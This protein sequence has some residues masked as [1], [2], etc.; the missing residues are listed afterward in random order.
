VLPAMALGLSQE[1]IAIE[2]RGLTV[3]VGEG[4]SQRVLGDVLTVLE[5]RA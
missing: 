5:G 4:F 2:V 1:A 3:R